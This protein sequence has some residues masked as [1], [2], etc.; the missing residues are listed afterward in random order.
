MNY[1]EV[2]SGFEASRAAR[3]AANAAIMEKAAKAGE[4]LDAEAQ[5]NFDSNTAEIK[6]IDDHLARL[7]TMQEADK[8]AAVA[9]DGSTAEKASES[10]GGV[11]TAQ[12]KGA[13][14]PK[15]AAF[16]RFV[17]AVARTK[18]DLTASERFAENNKAWENT[19]EVARVLK[20]AAN[21][22][23]T[24]TGNWAEPLT[25]YLGMSSEFVE[26]LRPATI[27]GRIDG[28]RN[29]PFN[30]KLTIQ[31]TGSLV[32]WVGET[33]R[34]PVG[35]PTFENV[36]MDMTKAAG[37]VV[38]SDELVRSSS[39]AAEETVK[40]TLRN[41]IAQF[42]DTQFI[43]PAVAAVAGVNPASITN[44]ATSTP[45]GGA[46]A[47]AARA[48]INTALTAMV[49]ANLSIGD[50]VI[51]ASEGTA[52]KLS[53]MRNALGQPEF[54]GVTATGGLLDGRPLITSQ[55]VP[56]GTLVI[57]KASEILLAD[58]GQV[59]IDVSKEATLVMDTAPTDAAT[60][61]FNLWQNNAIGIRAERFINWKRL[62]TAAVQV[63]TGVGAAA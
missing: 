20:A 9:V 1:A 4:T 21:A 12:V 60:P 27:I 58:D 48:A 31:L 56:A 29:V 23:T 40:T 35:N 13:N 6:S 8:A 46:S 55:A 52:L 15:G 25:E 39:P 33:K 61:S 30:T 43:D 14:A 50:V 47:D 51:I 5:E 38:L 44:G 18:G 42:L 22:G 28:L 57:A 34:K 37:I 7:K 11:V 26:L 53:T 49:S 45:T 16:T 2:I 54:D 3:V 10:R 32:N 63:V 17:M 62:R 41:D 59:V 24:Q 19:P 36:T